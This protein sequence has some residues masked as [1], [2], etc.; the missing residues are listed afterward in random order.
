MPTWLAVRTAIAIGHLR[1]KLA[2]FIRSLARTGELRAR[3]R[4][5]AGVVLRATLTIT[6]TTAAAATTSTT[7]SAIT[8][9]SVLCRA[10]ARVGIRR[11]F[12]RSRGG[13]VAGDGSRDSGGVRIG[14]GLLLALAF[15]LTLTL[16]LTLGVTLRIALARLMFTLSLARRVTRRL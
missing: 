15:A 11:C 9:W 12:V 10:I 2:L 7:P 8:A 4:F 1:M 16:C 6:A 5:T 14:R 13:V 3:L